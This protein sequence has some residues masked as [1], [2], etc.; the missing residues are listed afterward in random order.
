MFAAIAAVI[1]IVVVCCVLFVVGD[2][3]VET[4][5]GLELSDEQVSQI[6]EVSGISAGQSIFAVDESAAINAVEK[7]FPTLKAVTVERVFP[8]EVVI[9]IASRTGVVAVPVDGTDYYVAVDRDLKIVAFAYADSLGSLAVVEGYSVRG[10]DDELLGSFLNADR[11]GWLAE[12]IDGAEQCYLTGI[13]LGEFAPRIVYSPSEDAQGTVTVVTEGGCNLRLPLGGD[14]SE[15]F[16]GAYAFFD[17]V[18]EHGDDGVRGTV[19]LDVD[20]GG[21]VFSPAA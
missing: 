21:W 11:A 17:Q 7:A 15:T 19:Y 4:V 13:R 9:R 14:L 1:V 6:I 12:I 10:G 18:V 20:R 3:T 2:V 16:V 8:R 5:T